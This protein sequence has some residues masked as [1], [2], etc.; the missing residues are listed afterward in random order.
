VSGHPNAIQGGTVNRSGNDGTITRFGWKAQNKCV[1][2]MR[3]R[4]RA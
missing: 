3:V 1:F 4:N 2:P